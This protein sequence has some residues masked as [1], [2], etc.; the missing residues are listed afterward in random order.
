MKFSYKNSSY[1]EMVEFFVS[2]DVRRISSMLRHY[3]RRNDT[4]IV[5][6]IVKAREEANR[7]KKRRRREKPLPVWKD[8]VYY[9]E[10]SAT[11]LRWLV[12]RYHGPNDSVLFAKAGDICGG[13]NSASSYVTYRFMYH[14]KTYLV[15][16]VIWELHNG[17]IE[18]GLQIDHVD[19]NPANNKLCNL[20][21]VTPT[22]NSKNAKLRSDNTSGKQ[23]VYKE[24]SAKNGKVYEYW[25]VHWQESKG[26]K[27]R[28]CFSIRTLGEDAAFT[29]AC[30]FRDA[31]IEELNQQGAGYTERHGKEINV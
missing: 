14:Y 4:L 30:A 25:V 24:I 7:I 11:C 31:K 16:R 12:D 5:E 27:R 15:H 22:V 3:K 17:V 18:D 6:K 2:E 20:R 9:D 19:G 10:T 23:G 29:A 21:L 28:K 26:K 13:I 1:E 8:L